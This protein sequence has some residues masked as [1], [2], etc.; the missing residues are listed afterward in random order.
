MA[1]KTKDPRRVVRQT[2]SE[3]SAQSSDGGPAKDLYDGIP[4][5]GARNVPDRIVMGAR[6]VG[7][8]SVVPVWDATPRISQFGRVRATM[9]PPA[10]NHI[11]GARLDEYPGKMV[12]LNGANE[13]VG[14]AT[15]SDWEWANAVVQL[16]EDPL[17]RKD[18]V[19]MSHGRAAAWALTLAMRDF[20][21][22]W[23]GMI[24]RDRLFIL[25][26]WELLFGGDTRA[27][28]RVWVESGSGRRMRVLS[29]KS[30]HVHRAFEER[31]QAHEGNA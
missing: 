17:M 26:V 18:E 4:F 16:S 28:I 29:P 11:A 12:A 20:G 9:V 10:W 22:V 13:T 27:A 5:I 25:K 24:E 7:G 1:R 2:S 8:K 23:N 31:E 21:D 6:A 3:V 19:L 15:S 14:R 30:W